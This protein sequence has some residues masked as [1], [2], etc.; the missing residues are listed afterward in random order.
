MMSERLNG[1]ADRPEGPLVTPEGPEPLGQAAA[2]QRESEQRDR[3]AGGEAQGEANRAQADVAGRAG[4][5]DGG[6]HRPRARHEDRAERDPEEE[7]VAAGADGAL[8]EAVER[9]LD[10]VTE[11]RYQ[12]PET[13]QEQ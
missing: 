12:Q 10:Q 1:S 2:R 9:P 8:R 3:G 5:G 7:A 4:H 6:E 13:D 11:R